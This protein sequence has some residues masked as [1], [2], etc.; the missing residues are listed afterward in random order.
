[1]IINDRLNDNWN[2]VNTKE[3]LLKMLKKYRGILSDP[4]ISYLNS[5]IELEFSVIREYISNSDRESLSELEIYKKIAIYNI[6]NRAQ[7]LFNQQNDE[8]IISGN[9]N[10]WEGLN[11]STKIN[12]RN[13]S[14]FDFD[15]KEKSNI[16]V[17]SGF[18]SLNIGNISLFQTLE[19]EKL[20]ES[21]L[22]RVM[23]KLERLYD[24]KNPYPS[25]R[26]VIGGPADTWSFK[27]LEEIQKYEELF[28]QLD[29]KKE[30][31]DE[32]KKEIEITKL[33]HD[34]LLEDYG[35]TNKSFKK[36]NPILSIFN[37]GIDNTPLQKTFVKKMP[38]LNIKNNI[39]YI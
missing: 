27:H 14:L 35:L 21:E 3:E 20:R 4:M 25:R 1:M 33:F 10:G 32:D 7:N 18:K 15:Y 19:N 29:S 16:T 12:N 28:R 5:L 24:M 31:S 22:T 26:G 6:Y 38:N 11:V 37:Y 36:E 13:I 34:L 9:N 17:P 2:K 30:L 8:F 23:S 39:K